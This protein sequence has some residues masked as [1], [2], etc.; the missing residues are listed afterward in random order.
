MDADTLDLAFDGELIY[1]RGPSPHYFVVVPPDASSL[2]RAISTAVTYGWGAIPVR[3]R[4]GG[5]EWPT[6]L[7]PKDGGYIVPIKA[8]VRKSEQ[9][10]LGDTVK[11]Q[12][13]LG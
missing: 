8:A 5:H 6:S 2:I 9:L 4:L 11:L 1:W 12:L 10:E 13:S 7:F 3:V